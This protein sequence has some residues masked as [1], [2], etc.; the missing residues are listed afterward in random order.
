ML[1]QLMTKVGKTYQG[2]D[3]VEIQSKHLSFLHGIPFLPSTST[4]AKT[5][6][7]PN[8]IKMGNNSSFLENKKISP[9]NPV[10]N[11]CLLPIYSPLFLL[12]K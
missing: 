6:A 8:G 10:G 3:F 11:C 12:A 2:R 5:K 4:K 9:P 7:I 1:F